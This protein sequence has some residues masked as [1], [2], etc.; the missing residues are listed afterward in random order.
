MP[1]QKQHWEQEKATQASKQLLEVSEKQHTFQQFCFLSVAASDTQL[2][3]CKVIAQID[4][5]YEVTYN[6][7]LCKEII[8]CLHELKHHG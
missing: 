6:P 3:R 1:C 8:I 4:H 5:I 7:L 2:L